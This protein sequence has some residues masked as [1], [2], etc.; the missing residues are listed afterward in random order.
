MCLHAGRCQSQAAARC[1]RPVARF[2]SLGPPVTQDCVLG[3]SQP[4]L[5]NLRPT[6]A[7]FLG[8]FQPELA[9]ERPFGRPSLLNA[10]KRTRWEPPA[11]AGGATLQR[12]G[13]SRT[14]IN[15]ALAPASLA[16]VI[17]SALDCCLYRKEIARSSPQSNPA[18]TPTKTPRLKPE[19][20]SP[21]AN[22][23]A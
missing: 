21:I 11:L 15:R 20:N 3:T 5:R 6:P 2:P 19:E 10:L 16:G 22:R 4:S 23:S 8:Y 12:R 9:D 18:A 14:W 7:C 13:K 1:F 17:A